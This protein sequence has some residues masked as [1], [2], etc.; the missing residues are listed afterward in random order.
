MQD[1]LVED[2]P[3]IGTLN[4]NVAYGRQ[5]NCGGAIYYPDGIIDDTYIYKIIE[6]YSFIDRKKTGIIKRQRAFASLPSAFRS[7][8]V[9]LRRVSCT[10][11][12]RW[13]PDGAGCPAIYHFLPNNDYK[14]CNR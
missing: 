2:L 13:F 7:E 11:G 1:I 6:E 9:S 12:G 4:Q 5:A 3:Y 8:T 10:G 14:Y